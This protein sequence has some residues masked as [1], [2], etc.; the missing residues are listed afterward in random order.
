MINN[1][2][3]GGLSGTVFGQPIVGFFNSTAGTLFFL[4][5]MSP[6][7]STFQVYTGM[8]FPRVL[9]SPPP[10]LT[11]VSTLAG[12]FESYPATGAVSRSGWFAQA[13]QHV[14][15]KEKEKEIKEQKDK[16]KEAKDKDKEVEKDVKEQLKEVETLMDVPVAMSQLTQR[17]S[18]LEQR[19]A[20]GAAF[21][22]PEERP[23]VSG[24]ATPEP[25]TIEE[26]ST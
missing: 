18:L 14:K 9:T 8:V 20:A 25:P 23:P 1:D 5:V 7:V 17:V 10:N 21:I 13:T 3:A 15:G 11:F 2:G 24:S 12:S 19:L 22:R 4:R 26:K 16:E 6:D